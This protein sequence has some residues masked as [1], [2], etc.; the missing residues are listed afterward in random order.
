MVKESEEKKCE[1]K[2]AAHIE[3]LIS[4]EPVGGGYSIIIDVDLAGP[5]KPEEKK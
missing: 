1:E 4:Q 5:L 2:R 3:C